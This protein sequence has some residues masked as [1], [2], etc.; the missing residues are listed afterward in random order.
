MNPTWADHPA[1]KGGEIYSGQSGEN[2]TGVDTEVDN[3]P[4]LRVAHGYLLGLMDRRDAKAAA[5][6]HFDMMVGA[7]LEPAA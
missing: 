3:R 1:T 7:L 4:F 5:Q 6:K 2:S